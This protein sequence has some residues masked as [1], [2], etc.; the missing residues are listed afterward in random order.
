MCGGGGRGRGEGAL[1][2][3]ATNINMIVAHYDVQHGAIKILFTA[4]VVR[5]V[6]V[7]GGEGGRCFGTLRYK[8]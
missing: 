6:C 2:P 5:C 1:G 4:T 8:Y 7:G 3:Y